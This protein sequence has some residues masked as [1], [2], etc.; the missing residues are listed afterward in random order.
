MVK[1]KNKP[2]GYFKDESETIHDLVLHNDHIHSF[3][4]V[5]EALIEIC[6]HELLQAE[7]CAY[8]AHFKGKCPVK[9]GLLSVLK[10]KY[11]ALGKRGLT[12]TIE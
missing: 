4:F 11:T 8:I 2:S 7:Q 3:D 1:G 6:D 9:S 12:V 5:I 10:P